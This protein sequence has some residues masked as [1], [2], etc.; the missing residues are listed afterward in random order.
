MLK[1]KLMKEENLTKSKF[2]NLF[3]RTTNKLIRGST[4]LKSHSIDTLFM[5]NLAKSEKSFIT[6]GKLSNSFTILIKLIELKDIRIST[7]MTPNQASAPNI[8]HSTP[9]NNGEC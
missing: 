9:K 7:S 5:T 3:N 2:R 6:I 4:L 8:R 1:I